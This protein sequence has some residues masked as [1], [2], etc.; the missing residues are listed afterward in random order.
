[1]RRRAVSISIGTEG[2]LEAGPSTGASVAEG[3]SS[4]TTII[5]SACSGGGEATAVTWVACREVEIDR[6]DEV[7]GAEASEG[8]VEAEGRRESGWGV[9]AGYEDD[10]GD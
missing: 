10:A 1:M 2:G 7:G 8:K 6:K 5:M 9:E 3:V 4:S